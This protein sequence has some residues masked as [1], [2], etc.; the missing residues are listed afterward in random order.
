M[1]FGL[2]SGRVVFLL[3]ITASANGA[4]RVLRVGLNQ[5]PPYSVIGSDGVAR[6][7]AVEVIREAA[8]RSGIELELLVAP[9]GPDA[10]LA[11]GK[12][13]IFPLVT[14]IPERHGQIFFTDPWMRTRYVLLTR[15]G[16]PIRDASGAAGY[17]VSHGDS[18]LNARLA[19]KLF[20]RSTLI[21][22]PLGEELASV[23]DGAADATLVE[24]REMLTRLLERPVAC[25]NSIIDL[26]P[27]REANY[28]MAIGASRAG[29]AQARVLRGAINDMAQDLTLDRLYRQWLHDTGDE[30]AIVNELLN[31]RRRNVLLGWAS[32][33]LV[34]ALGLLIWLIYRKKST[35]KAIRSAY[36]FAK[37]V[38]DKAGGPVLIT[39]REG[40]IVR[41]NKACEIA[42][43]MAQEE[44]RGK[45]TWDLFVPPEE[46]AQAR[47]LHTQLASGRPLVSDEHHWRT[48]DGVRL[49]SWSYS[50][51]TD[52]AGRVEYI[53][54]T[55][56]DI[57]HREAVEKRLICEAARDPLT[58]L[59]NRRGFSREMDRAIACA[60]EGTPLRLGLA[61]LD[62][63]K[64]V[65]DTF[66]HAAGDDVLCFF[67][68]LLQDAVGEGGVAAR[69][70]GDEFC[71]VLCGPA[72]E[73]SIARIRQK[74]NDRE[75][76]SADGRT[77]RAGA[78][79]G[80]ASWHDDMHNA[81]DLLEAADQA[82]YE[83]KAASR[84][85]RGSSSRQM[86]LVS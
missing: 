70:G 75:F 52:A 21:A 5:S 74:M 27:L 48:A 79:F 76:R 1:R 22:K 49:F 2:K 9:E 29:I 16:A 55:G 77:F 14:D 35:Q 82:L 80:I 43:G 38:L 73:F 25:K 68:D 67:A 81:S 41:V 83:A 69:L 47:A 57:S 65:N 32:G 85:R 46:A 28:E 18:K 17:A 7:F 3:G 31:V 45:T 66:G 15:R 6:G 4:G 63:F 62:W 30:A 26:I 13:D 40:A 71:F 24:T 59:L 60:R 23:C 64:D 10:A 53:V 8:R 20:P 42:T 11:A 56:A 61:D 33:F 84:S 37:A 39:N 78:S 72:P 34:A 58:N 54:R 51:L 44:M 36:D 50:V 86:A 19:R 12:V